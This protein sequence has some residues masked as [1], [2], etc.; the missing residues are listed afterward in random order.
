MSLLKRVLELAA[1][2]IL[3]GV[4]GTIVA[5]TLAV[6]IAYRRLAVPPASNPATAPQT[7]AVAVL[8]LSPEPAPT[9]VVYQSRG[10]RDPFR[11]PRVETV[12]QEPGINLKLT[13]IVWGPRYHY[14]LVESGSEPEKSYVIRENSVVHSAKVLKITRDKVILEVKTRSAEGKPFTRTV[15]MHLPAER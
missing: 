14:A 11:Q 13:G 15:E 5:A 12:Q 9:P 1:L 10:R 8:S 6:F 4:L 2:P 7:P 3:I